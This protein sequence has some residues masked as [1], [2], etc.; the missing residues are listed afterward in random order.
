[1]RRLMARDPVPAD[2]NSFFFRPVELLGLAAGAS[3]LADKDEAPAR[4]LHGL[5]E[6]RRSL[7]PQSS[8]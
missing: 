5:L 6:T 8:I 4:W 7:L 3:T 1:M 2:R